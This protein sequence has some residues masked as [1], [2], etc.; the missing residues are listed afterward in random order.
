MF[1]FIVE[2]VIE[3]VVEDEEFRECDGVKLLTKGS[4]FF[5]CNSGDGFWLICWDNCS[6]GFFTSVSE[7]I[8][9]NYKCFRIN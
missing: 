7:L 9:K 2:L 8:K 3:L 1:G 5:D 6:T 4:T